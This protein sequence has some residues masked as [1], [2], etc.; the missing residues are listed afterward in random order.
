[1]LPILFVR[2]AQLIFFHLF[3]RNA[4]A[5]SF[6]S[7]PADLIKRPIRQRLKAVGFN[8][9]NS[10]L[11]VAQHVNITLDNALGPLLLGHKMASYEHFRSRIKCLLS[12]DALPW[13][14]F[15]VIP[16]EIVSRLWT[17]LN[18]WTGL[19]EKLWKRVRDF[20]WIYPLIAYM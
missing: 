17:L 11:L 7:F 2:I 20:H 18:E 19:M 5:S 13:C 16:R 6:W 3:N 15:I 1:M 4:S 8:F 10:G 14:N 12:A 9:S